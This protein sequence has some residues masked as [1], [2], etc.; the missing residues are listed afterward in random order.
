M[1]RGIRPD[2][3]NAFPALP[4][5]YFNRVSVDDL[6]LIW[7]YLQALPAANKKNKGNTLPIVMDWRVLQ[8]GWKAL[9][10][11]PDQGFFKNNPD[12]STEWNRGA[13]LVNGL[14]HCT[15]CHTPMNFVGA[16]KKKY[17]LTGSF[18]EGY[19][20]P[21]ITRRGLRSASR[22]QVADVFFDDQLINR[23]GPVRGPMASANHD[24]LRNL[25][26]SDRLAIATY[27]KSVVSRQPRNIPQITAEQSHLKRGQQVYANV[28]V[29]CHLQGKDNAPRIG[30]QANWLMRIK[31][32][33]RAALYRHAINGFNKMPP[34]G[35]CITCTNNDINAAV[36]YIIFHS[37]LRTQWDEFKNPA[38]SRRLIM[39][40]I[41]YGE[42]V[43]GEACSLCHD[44]GK[45]GAP[46][47]GN[48]E[49][50]APRIGKN[51]DTLI[52]HA[53]NGFNNM[54]AKG[55]CT[56]CSGSEVIAAVKY[57]VQSSQSGGDY[58]LW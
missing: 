27:L 11:Y 3:S 35:A 24:S 44:N 14:G 42:R 9:Y 43:Y 22:F 28:C 34:K 58:S 41:A 5:V 46:E 1:H 54:P 33:G 32:S 15:M 53:L 30:D 38:Q 16:E 12:Q 13:Y 55:G 26:E 36:D 23:A 57:M 7:V 20:A 31:Q 51:M 48:R 8:Y 2:G 18:I 37:L 49:Q 39:T 50:W 52:L 47:V 40:S 17:F 45:F 19:W 6:K 4:Y 56:Q 29:L 21:D 10:F 25:T